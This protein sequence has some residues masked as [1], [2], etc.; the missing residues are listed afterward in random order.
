MSEHYLERAREVLDVEIEGL[1]KVRDSL[2]GHFTNAITL[3]LAALEGGHKIVVTGVGKNIPIGQKIAATLTSTGSPAVFLHPSDAMHGELGILADGDAVLALSYSGE[4]E[5]M[6]NLMPA[7]KRAHVATIALTCSSDNSLARHCDE[8]IPVAVSAEACPFNMAPTAST[9]ATLAVGDALAM[10]L[11]E[12]RGFRKE[13]YAKL[14]PAGA[15]GRTLLLRVQDIMRTGERLAI[16]PRGAKIRDAVIAM[17]EA[18]AGSV[19]VINNDRTLAGIFTDGD[20]RRYIETPD[21]TSKP[22]DEFMTP[23]PISIRISQLAVEA[24]AIFEKHNIDDLIVLDE[25]GRLAGSVDIQD[26][27]KFKIL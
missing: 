23:D 2:D 13:D 14:H 18:R 8:V 22:I 11:L 27:P 1:H 6:M 21:L 16:V 10:V 24:L 17:S 19:A 4:S 25:Q 15:I 26:L 3:I 12:A 7:L 5:E 9:T 20:L